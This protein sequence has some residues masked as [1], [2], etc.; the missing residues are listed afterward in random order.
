MKDTDKI[1]ILMGFC[2]ALVA[3][4]NPDS[5]AQ[6]AQPSD[7][8]A[9]ET[10]A[11][12]R[13][14]AALGLDS[15]TLLSAA[16]DLN[17]DGSPEWIYY[18]L[19]GSLC[20]TG[21]CP[22]VVVAREGSDFRIVAQTTVTQLPIRRLSSTSNGWSDLSVAISGGGAETRQAKLSYD[23]EQYPSNPTVLSDQADVSPDEGEIL[24]DTQF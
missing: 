2:A 13:A 22:M 20:G 21:G 11:E 10:K 14:R 9:Q 19:D 7:D 3:C 24:I 5:S 8:Q 16:T 6:Q 23:G 1:A 4:S 18:A 17:S 12:D 15:G